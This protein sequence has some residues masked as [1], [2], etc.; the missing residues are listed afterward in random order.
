MVAKGPSSWKRLVTKVLSSHWHLQEAGKDI[1][2][3]KLLAMGKVKN[4]L[5]YTRYFIQQEGKSN[6]C[7]IFKVYYLHRHGL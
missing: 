2:L 4:T 6:T 7:K 1:S 3:H 5:S